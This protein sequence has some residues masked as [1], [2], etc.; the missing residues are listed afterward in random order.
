MCL[1]AR[2]PSIGIGVDISSLSRRL[3]RGHLTGFS[4]R[5][6]GET[7]RLTAGLNRPTLGSPEC[8]IVEGD[9]GEEASRRCRSARGVL[10]VGQ[11]TALGAT[12]DRPPARHCARRAARR[13]AGRD[14][15]R[16]ESRDQHLT[17]G[18]ERRRRQLR[19]DAARARHLPHQRLAAG[20]PNDGPRSR[21]VDGRAI[22]ARGTDAR[23]GRAVHRPGGHGKGA[24]AEYRIGD[25][26]PRR[27]QRADRRPAAE[28]PQLS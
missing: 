20:L 7:C 26:E 12:A 13:R 4:L 3:L 15:H 14:G 16:H 10:F 17:H 21:G 19:G 18:H 11:R 24:A 8:W 1:V 6:A 22:R 5:R 28:R 25:A 9:H 2:L 27:H 23:V